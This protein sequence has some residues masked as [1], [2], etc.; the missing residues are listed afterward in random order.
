MNFVCIHSRQQSACKICVIRKAVRTDI[1]QQCRKVFWMAFRIFRMFC[2]E[3]RFFL[4]T[5]SSLHWV[6]AFNDNN[7]KLELLIL[8]LV[9][10]ID[11]IA[12]PGLAYVTK[13]VGQVEILESSKDQRQN[14]TETLG[15]CI[16]HSPLRQLEP[17]KFLKKKKYFN[18]CLF[19]LSTLSFRDRP[20]P[21]PN[22]NPQT[23]HHPTHDDPNFIP[24]TQFV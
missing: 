22:P 23:R 16:L 19:L 21:P 20:S 17:L 8:K 2:N 24:S 14:W 3:R 10:R 6:I 18:R 15:F 4:A 13:L 7:D 5:S 11:N 9:I 1:S 12:I